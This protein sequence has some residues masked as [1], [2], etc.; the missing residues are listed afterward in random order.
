[1]SLLKTLRLCDANEVAE[2]LGIY[3]RFA[4]DRQFTTVLLQALL[5]KSAQKSASWLLKHHLEQGFLL[6]E[7]QETQLLEL[8]TQVEHW[9]VILHLLQCFTYIS[10]RPADLH[11]CFHNV[12]AL[13]QHQN[14]LVRAWAYNGLHELARQHLVYKEQ[15]HTI[16]RELSSDEPASVQARVRNILKSELYRSD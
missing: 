2:L 10:L 13:T 11:T 6:S 1:M 7:Q 14:K 8:V 15:V 16:M 4:T 12:R 5:Q 9:E 3:Q